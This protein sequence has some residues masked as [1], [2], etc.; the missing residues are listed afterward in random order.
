MKSKAWR[1]NIEKIFKKY[2]GHYYTTDFWRVTLNIE[3]QN[4]KWTMDNYK[5]G[6][7]LLYYFKL[8]KM[9]RI[10]KKGGYMYKWI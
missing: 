1:M 6:R 3:I 2:K 7:E 5:V 8:G 10:G 4:K 9:E